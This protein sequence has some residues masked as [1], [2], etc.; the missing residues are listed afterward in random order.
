MPAQLLVTKDS[1]TTTSIS[2]S[3][4]STSDVDRYE[5]M[6]TSYECPGD[7]DEG[8]VTITETSYI[9]EGLREGTSYSVTVSVVGISLSDSVTGRTEMLG[10]S[11]LFCRLRLISVLC[12]SLQLHLLL[13]VM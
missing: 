8:S 6:W 11:V 9:I 5:V 13:P 3:W 10:E 4:T 7:V 2:L 1:T 12:T